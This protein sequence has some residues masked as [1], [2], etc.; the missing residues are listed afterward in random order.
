[1]LVLGCRYILF[2]ASCAHRILVDEDLLRD[3][4]L[5]E[6][7]GRGERHGEQPTHLP[8]AAQRTE[9]RYRGGLFSQY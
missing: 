8:L 2:L 5:H 4:V 6:R 3:E 7:R 9:H 1:M